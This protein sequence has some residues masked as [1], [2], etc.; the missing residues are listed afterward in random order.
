MTSPA[1]AGGSIPSRSSCT[2]RAW[3][4][5]TPRSPR[6]GVRLETT[7]YPWMTCGSRAVSQWSGSRWSRGHPSGPAWRM[8][9]PTSRFSAPSDRMR[10]RGSKMRLSE[11]LRTV[12][13]TT[14]PPSRPDCGRLTRLSLSSPTLGTDSSPT[15]SA[16]RRPY[17]VRSSLRCSSR[18][19]SGG[20]RSW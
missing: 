15:S 18:S 6:T 8:E 19:S 12:D 11:A 14:P 13:P 1:Q 2:R 9:Q 10:R 17:T 5:S 3:Q 4:A 7:R 16:S 20:W